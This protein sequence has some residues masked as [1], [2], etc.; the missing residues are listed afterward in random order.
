MSTSVAV[1]ANISVNAPRK[2]ITFI[3]RKSISREQ[4]I[5][6]SVHK[7]TDEHHLRTEYCSARSE[8]Q[9]LGT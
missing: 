6:R 9:D 5:I 3:I 2:V 1:L 8:V 7:I 4:K